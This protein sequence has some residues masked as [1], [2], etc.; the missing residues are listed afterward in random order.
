MPPAS[1][2]PATALPHGTIAGL[3]RGHGGPHPLRSHLPSHPRSLQWDGPP[4]PLRGPAP[5][6]RRPATTGKP[7]SVAPVLV[8]WTS[9]AQSTT[10]APDWW[11]ALRLSTLREPHARS[12]S[13]VSPVGRASVP[14]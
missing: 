12:F 3:S 10:R 2:R 5:R 14:V 9:A 7:P 6:A 1:Q 4:C 8:G 13:R 11:T